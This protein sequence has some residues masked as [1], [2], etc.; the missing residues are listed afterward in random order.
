MGGKSSTSSSTS[1]QTQVQEQNFQD[2]G[3]ITAYGGSSVTYAPT[4]QGA[5]A[6]AVQLGQSVNTAATTLGTTLG[7]GAI[8]GGV[9]LGTAGVNAGVG[10]GTAGLNAATAL[11]SDVNQSAV[12]L[13]SSAIAAGTGVANAG[14]DNAAA[15][16]SSG[17]TFGNNAISAIESLTSQFATQN[18]QATQSALSGYQSIAQQNSASDSSQIQKVALYLIGAVV[19]IMVVPSVFRGGRSAGAFA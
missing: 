3:G 7:T 18:A 1:S 10:L 15:A 6:A 14:L 12:D 4:D 16:Y 17:L 19:L 8:G 2:T 5:T 13:G 9:S 11:S